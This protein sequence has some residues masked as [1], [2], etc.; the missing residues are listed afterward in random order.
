[1]NC[2]TCGHGF[3]RYESEWNTNPTGLR[4]SC[5]SCGDLLTI[6][7]LVDSPEPEALPVS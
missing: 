6:Y 2:D 4:M 7:E 1:M 5:P 3:E